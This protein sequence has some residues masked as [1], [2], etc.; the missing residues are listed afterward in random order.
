MATLNASRTEE[1]RLEL[2]VSFGLLAWPFL[3][4]ALAK[5]RP[6]WGDEVHFLE[7]VR[8]F[9]RGLSWNLIRTYPEMSAPLT[10]LVYSAWGHLVG[11]STPALRLLSP[12]IAGATATLWFLVIRRHVRGTPIV[13]IALGCIV[14]N[15]YFV[16]L[17]VFVFTDM[18]SLLGLAIVAT[19]V[20][21]RRPWLAGLGLAVATYARQY[22]VFLAPAIVLAGF[23]GR[24]RSV[25]DG[26]ASGW[27]FAAASVAGLV[28]LFIL[29][30]LWGGLAPVSELRTY[31]L[32]EGL[33]FDP[34][35][36]SLYL[37]APG[38]YLIPLA[39]P[40]ALRAR[41]TNWGF[42]VLA[43][44]FVWWFPVQT[45]IVQTRYAE[46]TVGFLHRAA[47]AVM[48]ETLV[49][50]LFSVLAVLGAAA[51]LHCARRALREWRQGA[52]SMVDLFLWASVVSFLLMMPLSYMPWEKYAL[53]LL[54][55]SSLILANELEH[56]YAGEKRVQ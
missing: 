29:Y 11:F 25:A 19:G 43:G 33:R 3:L 39:L 46:Y 30:V 14:F 41:R 21:S 7:T 34:H 2:L 42:A 45:T 44:L 54:M 24:P 16:G 32:S 26:A 35:A 22:L 49:A 31:F 15:P 37:A 12:V 1:K 23:L 51:M 40:V 55:L 8:L 36:L 18:L 10:Y 17:S 48:P 5:D 50:V 47:V 13:L 53:P 38:A 56:E 4:W 52:R 28:P 27:W 6:P 9:G 20:Q